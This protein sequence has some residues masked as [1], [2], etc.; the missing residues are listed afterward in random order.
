MSR[1]QQQSELQLSLLDLMAVTPVPPPE[2]NG[3]HPHKNGSISVI[4]NEIVMR[5][6]PQAVRA[7]ILEINDLGL[8]DWIPGENERPYSSYQIHQRNLE[9]L[10]V[11]KTQG[12]YGTPNASQRKKLAKYLGFGG[13]PNSF[14]QDRHQYGEIA[15]LVRPDDLQSM[16]Q[17]T[18]FAFYTPAPVVGAMWRVI[19]QM[20]FRGGRILEPAAGVG[21]F[22]GG[23][24]DGIFMQSKI[25]AVELETV[26]GHICA[27]LY[28][29]DNV[30]VHVK[31]FEETDLEARSFDLIVSNVPFGDV[32]V[33]DPVIERLAGKAAVNTIHDYYF[34]R[35]MHLLRPGGLLVFLTSRFTLD[36]ENSTV[37]E[38][39]AE[40]ADLVA[41]WRLPDDTF[42]ETKAVADLIVLRKRMAGE[43]AGDKSWIH[44]EK[45][46]VGKNA[47]AI[48]RWILE[49]P[50]NVIGKIE[51]ETGPFGMTITVRNGWPVS[52]HADDI[53]Y[54]G[55]PVYRPEPPKAT[56]EAVVDPAPPGT[57]PGEY[58][59]VKG[60][61]YRN[62]YYEAA[63]QKKPAGDVTRIAAL[64]EL[65]AQAKKVLEASATDSPS[66]EQERFALTAL[67]NAFVKEHGRIND[68]PNV[69]AFADDPRSS[70]VRALEIPNGKTWE[71]S[72]VFTRKTVG[73]TAPPTHADSVSD[74]YALSLS[75][76]GRIDF[77][78]M[79]RLTGRDIAGMQEEL[80][81]TIYLNPATG[82]WEPA[83]EYL[84]GNV[85][86][87][88]AQAREN[89][90]ETNIKALEAVQ[91]EPV[92]PSEI[93]A[94]LGA[95]WI[96]EEIVAQFAN[97][98]TY[99]DS[100]VNNL[101]KP[102]YQYS[103]P[104]NRYGI[105]V[106]HLPPTGNWLVN[107]YNDDDRT[108]S[109]RWGTSRRSELDILRDALNQRETSIYDY[110]SSGNAVL[111]QQETTAARAMK[112]M[113]RAAFSSWVWR[114]EQRAQTLS[115]I[116]NE[117][118]NVF[119]M[120]SYDGSH[121][122]FPGLS[123]EFTPRPSQRNA[124]W[125]ILRTGST[126]LWHIVGA[127]KTAT[128]IMAVME[129]RRLGLRKK[130]MIVVPNHLVEQF[131]VEWYRL[132]P[133]ADLQIIQSSDLSPQELQ[134][135][136]ARIATG[137][138]DCVI[139]SQSSFV[140]I[141]VS[142]ALWASFITAEIDR[143][144]DYLNTLSYSKYA[145]EQAI[146]LL[147]RK[148]RSLIVK[149]KNRVEKTK[150]RAEEGGL[151][152]EALGAD[153]LLVD[154]AQ[155]YKNVEFTTN[156]QVPGVGGDGSSI[157]YDLFVKSQWTTR[158]CKAGHLLGEQERCACGEPTV[159]GAL[160]LA[161]GTALD[162]SVSELYTW[163]RF[164]QMSKLQE[165][166]LNHFDAWA[167][168]FGDTETVIEMKPSGKG[169]RQKTRF[170]RFNNVPELI[171]L[172]GQVCDMQLDPDVLK[173]DRPA[174]V[175][176]APIPVECE[177]S[178]EMAA[179]IDQCAAR[180]EKLDQVDPEVDNI[181]KIMSDAMKAATD[182]RMIRPDAADDPQSKINQLVDRVYKI[183][184]SSHIKNE[185]RTQA[186]FLD[187]GTPGGATFNLYEDIRSKL[188]GLGIPSEQ[189]AFAQSAKTDAEKKAMFAKVDR[190]DIRIIIGSTRR[191]GTGVNMQTHLYALHH[192]D[193]PWTPGAIEQR[194]G[195]IL[196]SGNRHPEVAIYRYVTVKSM[197]FY[198]WHL[199]TLKA[200]FIKQLAT[201]GLTQR[202]VQDMENVVLS[203][204]Q[205]KAMAT[206]DQRIIEQVRVE[207]SYTQLHALYL[208]WQRSQRSMEIALSHL[209][210]NIEADE[211]QI[212]R[213][214]NA[215]QALQGQ[216]LTLVVDG[217]EIR[218]DRENK[219]FQ[220]LHDLAINGFAERFGIGPA[221]VRLKKEESGTVA[222]VQIDDVTIYVNMVIMPSA[223]LSRLREALEGMG[224]NVRQ[225]QERVKQRQQT[226]AQYKVETQ[227]PFERLA[228]LRDLRKRLAELEAD[229]YGEAGQEFD[230]LTQADEDE[231]DETE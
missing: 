191:M 214:E 43:V 24:P 33:H 151:T 94:A 203:F 180:A 14:R 10:A 100:L 148:R 62:V 40:H 172:F 104:P 145:N 18:P 78:Y 196:R 224:R 222:H 75:Q 95:S 146:K 126:F 5:A 68:R 93:Y 103:Y 19:R 112:G 57:K 107:Q 123:R 167:A 202:S 181:L 220:R 143:I 135:S 38:W 183:W 174:L 144:N 48:N 159:D 121:L 137:D 13:S 51:E 111:N 80:S 197:D 69:R 155:T 54:E 193:A 64:I 171:R 12:R 114:D 161:T 8:H 63:A 188:V 101:D 182:M 15:G 61:L 136:L 116:Y 1:R 156:L 184:E 129:S 219:E 99:D 153:M 169:W 179:Y 139:L 165:L 71:C 17:A 142:E 131:T 35:A 226:L 96:P 49:H 109:N 29:E 163:Q 213:Y 211:R 207:A 217:E 152:W 70:F 201:G 76:H 125:R 9:A 4:P 23:M 215:L 117:K 221:M 65:A 16:Q 150:K 209:P 158:R 230:D 89:N 20:G 212:K 170:V 41:A 55:K 229:I 120:P 60:A 25:T 85:A 110:D 11:Y 73:V 231:G 192:I 177:P 88:L 205:M 22:I 130:P 133:L 59:I 106:K 7:T 198:R 204:S 186:I 168:Q 39:L 72:Q 194:D 44:S 228:E 210:D 175:D 92:L 225:L 28:D 30:D 47:H 176:G 21:H 178:E 2:A 160:V 223:N 164:L 141:P 147:E 79:Q 218:A 189:I 56:T 90:L 26:A 132:Y 185:I 154:E 6:I 67:Y 200:N 37:R 91:P 50:A 27:M 128:M 84:A 77:E 119:V 149:M 53:Q 140:R 97:E 45:H 118:F 74:A 127:G 102:D 105:R 3:V 187:I 227:R 46:V 34:V 173:L 108:T 87:K 157:A 206:G 115:K 124:V 66:W 42:Y 32:P 208:Q 113:M 36:K 58:Y 81:G 82:Q 98:M 86:Q 190:G 122:S 162:N 199:I 134:T 31:A 195:R 216:E 166:G 138:H 83:D 52:H